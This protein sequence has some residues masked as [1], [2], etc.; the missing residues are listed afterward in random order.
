MVFNSEGSCGDNVN[1]VKCFEQHLAG[2]KCSIKLTK[3][4]CFLNNGFQGRLGVAKAYQ[5]VRV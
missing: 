1:H 3:K 2:S 5:L 4:K